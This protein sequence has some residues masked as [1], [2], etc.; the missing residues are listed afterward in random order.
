MKKTI[1]LSLTDVSRRLNVRMD[2]GEG[3]NGDVDVCVEI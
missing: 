3:L 1:K 2:R